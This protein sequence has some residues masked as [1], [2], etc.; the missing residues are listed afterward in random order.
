[1]IK[2]VIFFKFYILRDESY[3]FLKL[4]LLKMLFEQRFVM[5]LQIT[6]NCIIFEGCFCRRFIV[7]FFLIMLY[8]F[9]L[10]FFIHIYVFV[11]YSSVRKKHS[12]S[13]RLPTRHSG[14]NMKECVVLYIEKPSK[15]K[16][17]NVY[18]IIIIP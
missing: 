14:R 17:N 6:I 13:D 10:F 7:F 12:T 8:L 5:I 9:F 16:N 4:F 2:N 18:I 1:M 15:C 11:F 3:F